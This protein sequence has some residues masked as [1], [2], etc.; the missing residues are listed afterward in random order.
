MTFSLSW[1]WN[2]EGWSSGFDHVDGDNM[3]HVDDKT[4]VAWV[5]EGLRGI[6]PTWVLT[7]RLLSMA[8]PLGLSANES[9]LH[10]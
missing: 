2:P 3:D 4:Q 6:L 8:F 7:S 1:G 10:P 5:L 9:D